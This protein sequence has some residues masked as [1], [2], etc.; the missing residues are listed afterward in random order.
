[1]PYWIVTPTAPQFFDGQANVAI[2]RN[3]TASF[4]LL[5]STLESSLNCDNND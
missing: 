1:M 2:E 5:Y 4:N 3:S